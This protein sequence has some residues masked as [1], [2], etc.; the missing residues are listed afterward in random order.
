MCSCDHAEG[1]RPHA[2]AVNEREHTCHAVRRTADGNRDG[3]K[4]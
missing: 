1:T 3:K 4:L 2:L